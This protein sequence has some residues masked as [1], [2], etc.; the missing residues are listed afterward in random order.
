MDIQINPFLS[1]EKLRKHHHNNE[2]N[3]TD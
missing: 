1:I 2:K 3:L